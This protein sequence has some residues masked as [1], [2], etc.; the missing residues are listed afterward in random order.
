VRH[1]NDMAKR[2]D[3]SYVSSTSRLP[4]LRVVGKYNEVMHCIK[5]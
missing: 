2:L 4:G 1:E 5:K 3:R